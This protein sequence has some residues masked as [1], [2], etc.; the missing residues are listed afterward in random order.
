MEI[1]QMYQHTH[2]T[3]GK[4]HRSCLQSQK[5]DILFSSTKLFST[6]FLWNFPEGFK[7][8]KLG[9]G[10]VTLAIIWQQPW[11]TF[12]SF[13]PQ[14]SSLQFQ[15]ENSR[16]LGLWLNTSL[17]SPTACS[18]AS[19]FPHWRAP[20]FSGVPPWQRVHE[21]KASGAVRRTLTVVHLAA[22]KQTCWCIRII[23][24][25]LATYCITCKQCQKSNQ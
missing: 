9:F 12:W 18:L 8:A 6:S 5:P 24:L 17:S 19:F 25:H 21:R 23:T 22:T 15:Y 1:V 10:F 7:I 3:L 20:P 4:L 14:H 2:L 11:K 16:I 13:W